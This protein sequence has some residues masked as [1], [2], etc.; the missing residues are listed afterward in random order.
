MKWKMESTNI[1]KL[2]AGGSDHMT[3]DNPMVGR[4]IAGR[5]RIEALIG[6]GGMASVYR[7][8]DLL[9]DRIVAIKKLS[10]PTSQDAGA[11][12]QFLDEARATA[13]LH[14][15]S[16]V[17]LHDA[18]ELDGD[19]YLVAE[20]VE[21]ENLRNIIRN[22][23][24]LPTQAIHIATDLADALE[25]AHRNGIIH[26]DIKPENVIVTPSGRPK[27]LDFGIARNVADPDAM[28][29]TRFG[30]VMYMAPEQVL[31][32]LPSKASDIYSLGLILFE[33]LTGRPPV[34]GAGLVSELRAWASASP[35]LAPADRNIVAATAPVISQA[36]ARFPV[37]RYASAGTMAL[38]LRDSLGQPAQVH[39]TTVLRP[40]PVQQSV[41]ATPKRDGPTPL[42]HFILPAILG[43]LLGGVLIVGYGKIRAADSSAANS[44]PANGGEIAVVATITPSYTPSAIPTRTPTPTR[45]VTPTRT[46]TPTATRTPTRTP[47]PT[48]TATPTRTPTP[49]ATPFRLIPSLPFVPTPTNR[50]IQPPGRSNQGRNGDD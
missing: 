14:H 24:V 9:L 36:T 17:T 46:P 15:P 43:V 10:I 38:A 4:T 28:A 29:T 20:Y 40:A 33:M 25:F 42:R 45:T 32:E 47:T 21:G 37:D 16:I 6:N 22:H 2:V 27:L 50:G 35:N 39:H 48:R 18:I 19:G 3:Q 41:P 31:G 1:C 49:T 8:Q 23:S 12:R 11:H 34:A 5:Y 44:P 30:T 13:A 26:G 7:A